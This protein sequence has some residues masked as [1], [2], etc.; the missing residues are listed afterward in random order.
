MSTRLGVHAGP[1]SV[2]IGGGHHRRSAT[3]SSPRSKVE[4]KSEIRDRG[5]RAAYSLYQSPSFLKDHGLDATEVR[6]QGVGVH[7]NAVWRSCVK[8]AGSHWE[9]YYAAAST[10]E[11]LA[12]QYRQLD[13]HPQIA[14]RRAEWLGTRKAVTLLRSPSFLESQNLDQAQI[15]GQGLLRVAREVWQDTLSQTEEQGKGCLAAVDFL[16]SQARKFEQIDGDDRAAEKAHRVDLLVER[17]RSLIR[18]GTTTTLGRSAE[19]ADGRQ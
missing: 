13:H 1:F 7:A 15:S 12:Q 5:L 2:S 9:G 19:E 4:S 3:R 14:A 16:D 18:P 8:Q 6:A 17:G 11:T 10:L